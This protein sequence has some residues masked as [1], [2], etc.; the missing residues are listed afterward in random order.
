[1]PL[2][3]VQWEAGGRWEA[4]TTSVGPVKSLY[5]SKIGPYLTRINKLMDNHDLYTITDKCFPIMTC[6]LILKTLETKRNI[7]LK[8]CTSSIYW[9]IERR[10]LIRSAQQRNIKL[11]GCTPSIF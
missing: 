2:L 4:I 7:K 6:I 10:L 9:I 1:M 5:H 3:F 8:G 11:K